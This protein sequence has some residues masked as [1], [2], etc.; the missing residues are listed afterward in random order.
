[1]P[2]SFSIERNFLCSK[3]VGIDLLLQ[4]RNAARYKRSFDH[5]YSIPLYI[6]FPTVDMV[7]QE[8]TE[9]F[10]KKK[11]KTIE[12]TKFRTLDNPNT[13]NTETE[14]SQVHYSSLE[15]TDKTV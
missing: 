13:R 4:Q 14:I 15:N 7:F 11:K 8:T 2:Q 9:V 12:T 10:K 3:M 5:Q 1:M 6:C